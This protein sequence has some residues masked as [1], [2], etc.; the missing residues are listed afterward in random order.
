MYGVGA[1]GAVRREAH[2]AAAP[3]RVID[4][5]GVE[6]A[7]RIAAG[8]RAALDDARALRPLGVEIE[9]PA[10]Q[11]EM[12]RQRAAVDVQ[13][14]YE[15]T[16]FYRFLVALAGRLSKTVDRLLTR[17]GAALDGAGVDGHGHGGGWMAQP[18][19]AGVADLRADASA[20]IDMAYERLRELYPRTL[21]AAPIEAFWEFDAVRARF[22]E[23]VALYY[24]TGE[25]VAGVGVRLDSNFGIQARL[26]RSLQ[27]RFANFYYDSDARGVR[28]RRLNG[29]DSV[30]SDITDDNTPDG[31]GVGGGG[32]GG[33]DDNGGGGGG[34]GSAGGGDDGGGGGGGGSGQTPSS[35]TTGGGGNTSRRTHHRS[36]GGGGGGSRQT[37]TSRGI[38]SRLSLTK[39]GV[40]MSPYYE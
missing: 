27:F 15:R 10:A 34:G 20:A 9:L 29:N 5:V 8:D 1:D 18:L 39:S 21:G 38:V 11:R 31:W 40:R 14:R 3:R 36:S 6:R 2:A 30:D 16:P 25:N 35:T 23:Y 19:V 26:M 22:A 13:R 12:Q 17:P 37:T 32:G 24:G 7:R 33:D 28:D 4:D